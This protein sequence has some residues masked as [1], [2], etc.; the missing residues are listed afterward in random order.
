MPKGLCLVGHLFLF[1]FF[2]VLSLRCD[3]GTLRKDSVILLK[4]RLHRT[5]LCA[6]SEGSIMK[7][8]VWD[9]AIREHESYVE[10]S[11]CIFHHRLEFMKFDALIDCMF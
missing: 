2:V 10:F 5:E 11:G 8:P 7:P 6:R 3:S 9:L 4:L 1:S